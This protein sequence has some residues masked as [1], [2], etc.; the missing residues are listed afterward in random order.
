M[1]ARPQVLP[2]WLGARVEFRLE[3]GPG[4]SGAGDHAVARG[5]WDWRLGPLK[6]EGSDERDAVCLV[7]GQVETVLMGYIR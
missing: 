5:H 3:F 6:R 7:C 4:V 1:K 2:D